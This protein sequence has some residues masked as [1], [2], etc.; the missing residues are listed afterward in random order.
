MGHSV[1]PSLKIL[2][3][4]YQFECQWLIF[5]EINF[6]VFHPLKVG[7]LQGDANRAWLSNRLLLDIYT[8]FHNYTYTWKRLSLEE[9]KTLDICIR[10]FDNAAFVHIQVLRLRP[11]EGLSFG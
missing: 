3:I 6:T 9:L 8:D 11:S 7:I 5:V 4:Y 2:I 10:L 1:S